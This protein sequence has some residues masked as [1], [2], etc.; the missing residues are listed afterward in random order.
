VTVWTPAARRAKVELARASSSG[1]DRS[2]VTK[3]DRGRRRIEVGPGRHRV[4]VPSF[5][6][7]KLAVDTPRGAVRLIAAGQLRDRGPA[8][9]RRR[10]ARPSTVIAGG[11]Q[12]GRQRVGP[13]RHRRARPAWSTGL[14]GR[15]SYAVPFTRDRVG[16]RRPRPRCGEAPVTPR[17]DEQARRETLGAGAPAAR[18]GRRRPVRAMPRVVHARPSP[19]KNPPP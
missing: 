4:T 2:M 1:A 11:G 3:P 8:R 17:A 10:P 19:R 5:G 13:D 7:A 12:G 16:R 15:V 9:A 14:D 6:R 18:Q